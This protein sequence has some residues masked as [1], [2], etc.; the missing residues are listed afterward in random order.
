MEEL[1]LLKIWLTS[2][3]QNSS[4]FFSEKFKR[5]VFLRLSPRKLKGFV[6]STREGV[7]SKNNVSLLIG[8]SSQVRGALYHTNTVW[9]SKVKWFEMG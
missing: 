8:L 6:I 9:V 2:R 7:N 5:G 1:C 3:H 4:N